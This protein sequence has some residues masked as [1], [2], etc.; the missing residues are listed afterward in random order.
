MAV[1]WL[2]LRALTA[3]GLGS[4]PGRGNEIPQ[5]M[6]CGQNKKISV[7]KFLHINNGNKQE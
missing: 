4:I 5:A 7:R 2:G 1:V 3:K 6:W